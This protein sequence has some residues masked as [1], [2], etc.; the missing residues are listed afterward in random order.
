M[1]LDHAGGSTWRA[2]RPASAGKDSRRSIGKSLVARVARDDDAS[3]CRCPIDRWLDLG[4]GTLDDHPAT[5]RVAV[6]DCRQRRRERVLLEHTVTT[7]Y[8][9]E[10]QSI[11][12]AR[13][14][15]TAG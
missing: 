10:R 15:R 13:V 1:R 9:W 11:D 2:C 7:P 6:I 14:R 8:R 3:T 5:F 12:L 4:V